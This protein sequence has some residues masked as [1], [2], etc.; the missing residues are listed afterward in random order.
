LGVTLANSWLLV[1]LA[2]AAPHSPIAGSVL[3]CPPSAGRCGRRLPVPR[4]LELDAM[5]GRVPIP[6]PLVAGCCDQPA[7]RATPQE[8]PP[9]GCLTIS[10]AAARGRRRSSEASGRRGRPACVSL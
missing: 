5:A 9:L 2:P 7:P 6:H 4:L 8:P 10:S 1:I 3:F